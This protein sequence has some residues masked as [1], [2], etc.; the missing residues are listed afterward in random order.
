MSVK[1]TLVFVPDGWLTASTWNKV[2][3]MADANQ[4]KSIAVDLPSVLPDPS[5]TLWTTLKLFELSSLAKRLKAVTLWLWYTPTLGYQ[6][7]VPAKV[8]HDLGRALIY[9][10]VIP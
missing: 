10:R 7:A 9:L 4:F 5:R 3:S 6:D 1:P 8:L 2:V